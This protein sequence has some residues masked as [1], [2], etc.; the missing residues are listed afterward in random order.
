M[1]YRL[2]ILALLILIAHVSN[3]QKI[4]KSVYF[5]NASYIPSEKTITVLDSLASKVMNW[6]EYRIILKGYTDSV[7]GNE[8]NQILSE[9]R[10]QSVKEYLISK[11]ISPQ[12]I[13]AQW[14]GENDPVMPNTTEK[15]RAGNRRVTLWVY[16]SELTVSSNKR[17][18]KNESSEKSKPAGENDTTII[19]TNGTKILIRAGT[20]APRQMKDIKITTKEY[21]TTCDLVNSNVTMI[22][23]SGDCLTSGGMVFLKFTS[24]TVEVHPNA[25]YTIRI[26]IP[27]S[28]NIIDKEMQ[29]YVAREKNGAVRWSLTTMTL[30]HDKSK[31]R[32]YYEF[33]SDSIRGFNIDKTIRARCEEDGPLVKVKGFRNCKLYM[34]Y[35]GE[36]YLSKGLPVKRNTYSLVKP[37]ENKVPRLTVTASEDPYAYIAS[38]PLPELKYKKNKNMYV[39]KRKYFRLYSGPDAT[40]NNQNPTLCDYL[41]M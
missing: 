26:S 21:N 14:Y 34:T 7:A 4:I 15:G 2:S 25:G 17:N 24:D 35:P 11:G 30:M 36:M 40:P 27:A 41:S 31:G 37:A 16:D 12:K 1:K 20:F 32:Y 39:L 22:T 29:V 3:G 28:H 19:C 5:D 38:G 18:E 33:E 23:D 8:Y 13:T 9:K 6:P 10:A